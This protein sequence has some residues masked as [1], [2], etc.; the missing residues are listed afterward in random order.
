MFQSALHEK[1]ISPLNLVQDDQQ[2]FL[3][4]MGGRRVLIFTCLISFYRVTLYRRFQ[5]FPVTAQ[6][7]PASGLLCRCP[8]LGAIVLAIAGRE[9]GPVAAN[10]FFPAF[11]GFIFFP[12]DFV[13]ETCVLFLLLW[14]N[15]ENEMIAVHS[16]V[17][18]RLIGKVEH[19]SG[20]I[21]RKAGTV[22]VIDTFLPRKLFCAAHDLIVL[23]A[24]K[25]SF[26]ICHT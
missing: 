19:M 4:Q 23:P 5:S 13:P 20:T 3:H 15:S 14:L 21:I 6:F 2:V 1:T 9:K 16:A 17:V 12:V 22:R 26:A 18:D 7:L 10:A 8:A 24:H 11:P 25:M